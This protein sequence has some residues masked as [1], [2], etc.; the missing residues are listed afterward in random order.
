[1]PDTKISPQGRGKQFMTKGYVKVGS[2]GNGSNG[3]NGSNTAVMEVVKAD[4]TAVIEEAVV[5]EEVKE[6]VKEEVQTPAPI[7]A[8]VMKTVPV[9]TLDQ[10]LEKVEE[11]NK[12]IPIIIRHKVT[13]NLIHMHKR[14]HSM[15]MRRQLSQDSPINLVQT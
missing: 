5:V 14:R 12:I 11:L 10:K 9:M 2:N 15:F 1:M 7:P 13:V 3:S 8:P 4:E 6:I